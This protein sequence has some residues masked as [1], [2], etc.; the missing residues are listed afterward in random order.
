MTNKFN[1]FNIRDWSMLFFVLVDL[2]LMVQDFTTQLVGERS[3][4]CHDMGINERAILNLTG[5]FRH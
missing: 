3:Q 1:P 5:P 2:R 4:L